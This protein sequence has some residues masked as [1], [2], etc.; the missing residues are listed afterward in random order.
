LIKGETVQ[1]N[2][3]SGRYLFSSEET[4]VLENRT[5]AE[6]QLRTTINRAYEILSGNISEDATLA[7][8]SLSSGNNIMERYGGETSPYSRAAAIFSEL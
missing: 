6:S 8:I 7:F 5:V 1:F 3:N 2:A 4:I